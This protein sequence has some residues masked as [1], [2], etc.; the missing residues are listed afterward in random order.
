MSVRACRR[1]C[2]LE[3][4]GCIA[5]SGNKHYLYLFFFN[6]VLIQKCGATSLALIDFMS[7]GHVG[8]YHFS[9]IS[10]STKWLALPEECPGH[11]SRLL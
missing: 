2:V 9:C 7:E 4:R 5:K 1:T 10:R 11:D 3:G 8:L 6:H